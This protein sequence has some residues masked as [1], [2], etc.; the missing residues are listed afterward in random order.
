MDINFTNKETYL[1]YRAEWKAQYKQ[2]SA[3]IRKAKLD[4]KTAQR[5]GTASW[6]H[7]RAC[8]DGKARAREML[9]QLR[10]AKIEAQRQ[11]LEQKAA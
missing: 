10:D 9:D 2:L 8:S 3:E 1:A 4:L 5:E 11:W 6:R 7:F